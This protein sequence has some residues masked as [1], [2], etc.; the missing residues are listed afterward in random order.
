MSPM[1]YLADRA[2]A[3]LATEFMAIFGDDAGREA[4]TRADSSRNRGN[5]IGFCRWRQ[6]ERMILFMENGLAISTLH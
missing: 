2:S 3:D 5:V 4:A 6:V 1:P